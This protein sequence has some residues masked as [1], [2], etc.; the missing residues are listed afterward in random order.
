MH[1]PIERNIAMELARVTEA[2]SLAA[3]RYLG[4]GDKTLVDG[5]AVAAMRY[6][7]GHVMMDGIVVI[8]EGEKDNAPML[9]IGDHIGN[10]GSNLAVDIAVDP[11]D[12]T[13]LVAGGCRV[14]Y[15]SVALS[16][17]GTMHCPREF[18][19]MDKI[20]T[21]PEAKDASISMLPFL[22]TCIISLKP[23]VKRWKRL[24]L[25]FW[26]GRAMKR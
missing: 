25:S 4:R 8:G 5:N 21:G 26:T 3:A 9:Y 11:I 10:N 16:A 18:F 19:Y 23:S 12:G 13:T 17:R 6:G 20:V 24:P 1:T 22:K 2:A 15:P 7:L 14:P